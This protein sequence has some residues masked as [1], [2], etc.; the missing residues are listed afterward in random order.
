[1]CTIHKVTP[2]AIGTHDAR[3][4]GARAATDLIPVP[5][6]NPLRQTPA[7]DPIQAKYFSIAHWVKD[8][9]RRPAK[10]AGEARP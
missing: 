1:M 9:R 8:R 2:T 3:S 5:K 6:L 10:P 4:A 7:A